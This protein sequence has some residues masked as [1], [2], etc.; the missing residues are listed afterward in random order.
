MKSKG[1]N[2]KDVIAFEE[3]VYKAKDYN[4]FIKRKFLMETFKSNWSI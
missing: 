1:L 2:D 3:S 4:E